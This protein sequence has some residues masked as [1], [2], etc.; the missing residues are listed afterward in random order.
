M[1]RGAGL[2]PR[3][4]VLSTGL[5]ALVS[6]LLLWLGWLLVGGVA[7]PSPRSRRAAGCASAD[8]IVPAEQVSAAVGRGRRRRCCAPG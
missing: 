8:S 5:V 3:L 4:T 1:W 2:R 7:K 6:A